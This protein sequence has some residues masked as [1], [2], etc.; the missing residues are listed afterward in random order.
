MFNFLMSSQN[1]IGNE[2]YMYQFNVKVGITNIYRSIETLY[3]MIQKDVARF[4]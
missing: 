4:I 2:F 3:W 1:H